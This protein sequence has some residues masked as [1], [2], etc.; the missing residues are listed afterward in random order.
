MLKTLR[1]T[2]KRSTF[3]VGLARLRHALRNDCRR[4]KGYLRRSSVIG[5]YLRRHDV[6]KIQLGAGTSRLDGWLNT[7]LSPTSS[8]T[9]YL[10]ATRRF[11]FE[12]AT[13][14][15]VFSEHLIEHLAYRDG[16]HMLHECCRVLSPGGRIRVAT[17]NLEKL[18]ALL[19]HEENDLHKRYIRWAID[20]HFPDAGGYRAAFVINNFFWDFNHLFVYDPETLRG[21]LETAGFVEVTQ[22]AP[23]ESDD[24]NLRGLES[25]GRRI[26]EE[27]N[28]FETMVFEAKRPGR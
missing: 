6:R 14:Q 28:R 27:M 26:G 22:H 17:P 15:Y 20:E 18:F 7:D 8:E 19:A 12:D 10:D 4:L 23:G 1:Q 5:A 3:V 9:V 24:E 16:L 25:H 2:A 21:S 11:P 13:A